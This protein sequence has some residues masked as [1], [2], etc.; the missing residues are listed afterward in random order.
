MLAE[1][2]ALAQPVKITLPTEGNRP[3]NRRARHTVLVM[4]AN[5]ANSEVP[6]MKRFFLF[7]PVA[8]ASIALPAQAFET[9]ARVVRTVPITETVNHPSQHCWTETRQV[10]HPPERDP[11]GA[12]LGTIAGGIIGS[13]IGKGRNKALGAAV[14]AG[15]GAITGD[16]LANRGNVGIV[17]DVPVQRCETVDNFESRITGY[18]V[19]YEY[20]NWHFTTQLPYNPGAELRVNVAV[21]PR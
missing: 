2:L 14:G 12:I 1:G 13:H 21:T 8:I 6:E 10:V 15:I 17:E 7:L 9:V 3:V 18:K 5:K 11:G 16:R 20:D 4:S 19:T